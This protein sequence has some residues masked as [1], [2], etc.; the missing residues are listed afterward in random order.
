MEKGE[1]TCIGVEGDLP[2]LV[3]VD[4]PFQYIDG[5]TPD[6]LHALGLEYGASETRAFTGR[7][8]RHDALQL[9]AEHQS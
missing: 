3:G 8:V 9:D 4:E 5:S 6:G 7:W 2:R 1:A